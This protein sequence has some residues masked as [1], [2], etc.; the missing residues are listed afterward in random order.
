MRS[1]GRH[2]G[3]AARPET[4][5]DRARRCEHA[6]NAL[7]RMQQR[8]IDRGRVLPEVRAS[9]QIE[10]RTQSE[11]PGSSD[12]GWSYNPD[13]CGNH[14]FCRSLVV[15]P[16]SA[17]ATR[18]PRSSAHHARA[19]RRRHGTCCASVTMEQARLRRLPGAGRLKQEQ[20]GCGDGAVER[21]RNRLRHRHARRLST[22]D[23]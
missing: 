14:H 20:L 16:G 4:C 22:E 21:I 7:S 18:P 19:W 11:R 9:V 17:P 6:G 12:R 1:R 10:R 23:G 15:T 2:D 5:E 13:S 3:N 8:G